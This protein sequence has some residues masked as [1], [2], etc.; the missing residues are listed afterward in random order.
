MVRKNVIKLLFNVIVDGFHVTYGVV[1]A[2]PTLLDPFCV[3]AAHIFRL[4][5]PREI[6][7]G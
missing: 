5:I 4:K 7:W 6:K 1:H 2:F 3:L